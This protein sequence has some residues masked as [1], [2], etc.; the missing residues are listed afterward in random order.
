MDEMVGNPSTQNDFE[1]FLKVEIDEKFFML[2]SHIL[3]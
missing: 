1:P 2:L 3:T